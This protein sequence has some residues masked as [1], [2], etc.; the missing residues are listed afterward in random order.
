MDV[1]RVCCFF[2]DSLHAE[3]TIA[4]ATQENNPDKSSC[5]QTKSGTVYHMVR[6]LASRR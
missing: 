5:S 4:H 6:Q 2:R 1:I 3:D